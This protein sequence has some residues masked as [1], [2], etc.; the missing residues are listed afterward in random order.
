VACSRRSKRRG[1]PQAALESA[2]RRATWLL[3]GCAVLGC[4][5]VHAANWKINPTLELAETYSD[6]IALASGRLARSDL[7]SEIKP[8]IRITADGGRLKANARYDLRHFRYLR[9]RLPTQTNHF[10]DAKAT[11]EIARDFFFLD[12]DAGV[13]Q[14]N[15]SLFGPLDEKS[16]RQL[17]STSIRDYSLS[18]YVRQRFGT[19]ATGEARYKWSV[20][21]SSQRNSQLNSRANKVDLSLASGPSFDTLR[22]KALFS[23]EDINYERALDTSFQLWKGSGEYRLTRKWALLGSFGYEKNDFA[24]LGEKPEGTLW[25][26]GFAWT[27]SAR[28]RFE[29]RGGHRFFGNT[30]ALNFSHRRRYSTWNLSYD[31]NVTSTRSQFSLRET[32]STSDLLNSIFLQRG[33][34]ND[35]ERTTL[36]TDTIARLGLPDS[37]N[38]PVNFQS[39]RTFLQKSWLASVAIDLPRSTLI[40][41]GFDI[42]RDTDTLGTSS[43]TV[44]GIDDFALSNNIQQ[45]GLAATYSWGLNQRTRAEFELSLKRNDF[46]RSQRTDDVSEFSVGLVRELKPRITGSVKYRHR[47]LDSNFSTGEYEENAILGTVSAEF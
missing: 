33:I 4:G 11:A 21:D 37:L 43:S 22:W 44:F 8:G 7:R 3:T 16:S 15:F 27:P 47:Y 34:T 25:D 26:A 14:E 20:V 17:N 35:A 28:T 23:N 39:N 19:I 5:A 36:V 18:P 32:L 38:T 31:E 40:L 13:R 46:K 42:T 2:C 30:Y 45:L 24:T 29:A 10:L 12:G 6:N 9:E 1:A 41:N